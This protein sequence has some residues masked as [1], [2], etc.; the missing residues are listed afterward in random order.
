MCYTLAYIAPNI[1]FEKVEAVD[2]KYEAGRSQSITV[3]KLGIRVQPNDI[4]RTIEPPWKTSK[5]A[6]PSHS[7][8]FRNGSFPKQ[9]QMGGQRGIR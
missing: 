6:V 4:V 5:H 1:D 3:K 8:N 2:H 7:G 9:N